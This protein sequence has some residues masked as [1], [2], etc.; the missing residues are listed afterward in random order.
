MP[1]V[2]VEALPSNEAV[3]PSPGLIDV[4]NDAV[5]ATLP[6]FGGPARRLVVRLDLRRRQRRLVERDLVEGAVEPATR[7]RVGVREAVEGAAA[8]AEVAV[9]AG[10][11][12]LDRR[13]GAGEHPVDVDRQPAR[14]DRAD[15][16]VPRV[17][18]VVDPVADRHRRGGVGAEVHAPG[19][20]HV[21]HAVVRRLPEP[22]PE[23]LVLLL[24]NP[25]I[26]PPFA[27]GAARNH[28]SRL[29]S[30]G[31]SSC[32]SD[33]T[34]VPVAP[35]NCAAVPSM[36]E[37]PVVLKVTPEAGTVAGRQPARSAAT[38]APRRLVQ[39]PA[40]CR[41]RWRARRRGTAAWPHRPPP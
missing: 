41:A 2:S 34:K 20:V 6:M 10:A 37:T 32:T 15:H 1:S 17:V 19:G 14:A 31:G 16:V 23:P 40:A 21:E 26:R 27:P 36:P 3:R 38:V 5:G 24:L 25:A 30:C 11:R 9:V 18:A 39:A 33:R 22:A 4:V 12:P 28:A 7:A 29:I 35:L 13:V 8:D